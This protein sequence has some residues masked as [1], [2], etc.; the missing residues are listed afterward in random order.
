LLDRSESKQCSKAIWG[1]LWGSWLHMAGSSQ[2]SALGAVDLALFTH[3]KFTSVFKEV[4]LLILF[5]PFLWL[6]GHYRPLKKK[7]RHTHAYT[8]TAK[9]KEHFSTK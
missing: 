7:K 3:T 8:Q 6:E 9:L 1:A 4:A 2:P 5:T